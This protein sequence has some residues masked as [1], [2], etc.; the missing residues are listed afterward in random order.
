MELDWFLAEV[1]ERT[2]WC[3]FPPLVTTCTDGENGGWFRNVT[4]G[5]NFW[6]AFYLPL[7]GAGRRRRG[8]DRAHL[9]QRLSQYLRRPRRG[10]GAHRGLEHRLAP[11]ARLHPVDRLG[12]PEAGHRRLRQGQPAV[13]D[14]RWYATERGVTEGPE[15]EAIEEAM[16]RLLRAETSCNILLGRGM[17][18]ARRGGSGGQPGRPRAYRDP[19]SRGRPMRPRRR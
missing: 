19:R 6:S 15:A 3:D 14:A 1:A 2:K 9:H 16:W 13:H 7:A 10:A 11:R 17:G 8:R 12:S 18:A 4:E 5:A